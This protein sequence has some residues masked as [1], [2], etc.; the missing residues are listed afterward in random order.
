MKKIP[1]KLHGLALALFVAMQG[2]SHAGLVARWNMNEA[3]GTI[4][5]SSGNNLTGTPTALAVTNNALV[6]GQ[7]SV[8]AA[9]YGAITVSPADAAKFGS[10]IQ[11]I[12]T[13][14]G[15]FQ[16]GNPAVIGDLASAGPAGTFTLMAWTNAAVTSS[17]NQRIFATGPSNGWG[18]GLSNVDQVIYTAFGVADR[19]STNAPSRNNQWQHVA[20]VWNAGAVQV[21]I[22]GVSVYTATAGFNNETNAQFGI[23]GNGNGGDHFNGRM[24]ELKIFNTAMTAEEIIA[25]ALPSA[26]NGPLMAIEPALN[27]TNNGTP[28]TFNIPFSNEGNTGN[29]TVTSVT[30]GGATESA[31]TVNNFTASVAPGQS[32]NVELGF[33]PTGGGLYEATLTIASN[34][35]ISPARTVTLSVNVADPTVTAPTRL[36]FGDLAPNPGS[37]TMSLTLTNGGGATDLVLYGVSLLGQGGN[38]FSIVSSPDSIPSGANGQVVIAFN[39]GTATGNFGDL[40]KIET[41]ATNT[42][43]LTIPVVAKVAYSAA[44]TSVNV[45]NGNFD[46]GAWNSLAGTAPAGW[47]NSLAE[48]NSGGLYGQG[49]PN[50]PDLTSIAA[51][52]QSNAGYYEQNLTTGNSGLTAG[53]V[54]AITVA[55]DR[56][57]RNDAA[58]NGHAMLRVSLWDKT[59]DVEIVGRDLLFE[60]PGVLA[61][62]TFTSAALR[63]AYDSSTYAD[64]QIAL[65][66]T[67]VPP[68]LTASFFQSTLV[69]DNVSVAVDGEWVPEAGYSSWVVAMG[70]DGTPGKENGVADDP[71]KD[72]VSNFDEFAFGGSPLSGESGILSAVS[73][74]DTTGDSQLEL[75]LTVAVRDDAVFTGVASPSGSAAGVTY[76]IQ[77]S[78]DLEEFI[79]A[80]DGP[81]AA[82]VIPAALPA[83]APVGYK[84]VSFRL[85][86]SNGLSGKGFLRASASG[87]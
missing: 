21:Y 35:S 41:N 8:P 3:S 37:Q 18:A 80:V 1:L 53:K 74:A 46:A 66:I 72:G 14:S 75:I 32:G 64:E 69:I 24:D 83:V 27:F 29:L 2:I 50:T 23:G 43:N 30:P 68:L 39:P 38:G 85:G 59:N 82:P 52:F 55:L 42:P 60:N 10:S 77:G 34:D 20:Y 48:T 15:M 87:N 56:F 49:A 86:G 61:G 13:L 47:T 31:F 4:A 67:R 19:R 12:R 22:N 65:R 62:N 79:A 40:L 57:Y 54:D 70:L 6:Y 28:Q 51:H 84:Y 16:I 63:L 26:E 17:T 5:D 11:F 36:D 81:L 73:S 76:A 44:A 45:V 71:D 33:E 78:F 25:A 7:S 58:T 9:T